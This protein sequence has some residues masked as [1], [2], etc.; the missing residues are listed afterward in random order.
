ME[1]TMS[2]QKYSIE[3]LQNTFVLSLM[4]SICLVFK[5]NDKN[6]LGLRS[7]KK[8]TCIARPKKIGK[9]WK[10]LD[11]IITLPSLGLTQYEAAQDIEQLYLYFLCLT[12]FRNFLQLLNGSGNTM[13]LYWREW[14][15]QLG[16][17]VCCGTSTGRNVL[18]IWLTQLT[19]IM[20]PD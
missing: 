1:T 17:N 20:N 13:E 10:S 12:L 3:P 18:S 9:S 19:Q 14:S 5:V 7:L 15:F 6:N 16:R 2:K 8:N 4:S 11:R